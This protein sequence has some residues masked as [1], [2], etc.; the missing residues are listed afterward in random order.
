[1]TGSLVWCAVVACWFA[2][3]CGVCRIATRHPV[4]APDWSDDAE[5]DVPLPTLLAMIAMMAAVW[6]IVLSTWLYARH[7]VAVA[8]REDAC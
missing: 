5:E 4:P 3:G 2:I 6:P 8:E 7:A 1:M